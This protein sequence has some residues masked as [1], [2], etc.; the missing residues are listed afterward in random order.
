MFGFNKVIDCY[1]EALSGLED[2]MTIIAGGFGACGVPENLITEVKNLGV[3]DLTVVSNNC[4]SDDLGLA[5]LLE[6]KQIKKMVASYVGENRL[7]EQQMEQLYL[8]HLQEIY[9][10]LHL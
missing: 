5:V 7:F 1:E 3:R 9:S 8:L 4:G 10:L 6:E 2:G